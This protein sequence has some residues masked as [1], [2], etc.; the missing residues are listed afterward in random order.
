MTS[1]SVPFYIGL[2]FTRAKRRNG[3]ISFVSIF[4]LV[5]MALCVFALIVVLSVMNGFDHELKQR[6]LR[7][8]AHG[9]LT[10]EQ[11]LEDWQ[12]LQARIASTPGLMA[13]APYI[14]GKGLLTFDGQVR[15]IQIQGVDPNSETGISAVNEH[16][17][18]GDLHYLKPGEY[19][20]IMGSLLARY[21]GLTP[22]DRVSVTLPE[23][24]ITP[25]GV[26]PRSK[27][28]T[29]VGVFE[30]G[31]QVDQYLALIHM[32]DGQKLFRRG[33]AV[34][35]LH[36]K[37]DDIYRAPPAV[38]ALAS[39]LGEGYLARDWSQTQ[40]SLFQAVKMEKT[41]VGLLLSILIAVAAFNIISSLVMMVSEKRSEI[42]VLRTLGLTRWGI[43]KV[44]MVQGSSLGVAGVVIGAVTGVITAVWLPQIMAAVESVTGF[45]VFDPNVYFVSYLPTDWQPMDTLLVCVLSLTVSV[46]ATLYPAWRASRI[47]PAEALRYDM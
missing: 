27:R 5:G 23:V 37:F 40:G 24:S 15:P 12:G 10:T 47:E 28:F 16:M 20:I 34:D 35:G 36:L 4:A 3:F 17:V 46:L 30:V 31:A 11:P 39:E 7:V 8:V 13:S 6:L 38:S 14:E 25:A 44:F 26:F 22:G 9:S 33:K 45:Q 18:V 29:L 41:M 42:A 43:M 19:G 21:L 1:R 32:G 2:R